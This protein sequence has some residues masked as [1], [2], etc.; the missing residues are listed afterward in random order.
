VFSWQNTRPARSASRNKEQTV[1]AECSRMILS[2][3]TSAVLPR[4]ANWTKVARNWRVKKGLP[5][6]LCKRPMAP[7]RRERGQVGV[8]ARSG[9]NS[10]SRLFGQAG[11]FSSVF[12]S[13]V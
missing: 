3:P 1:S 13:Q 9:S 6:V 7:R 12:L 5:P 2:V 4:S 10:S 8:D 11:N